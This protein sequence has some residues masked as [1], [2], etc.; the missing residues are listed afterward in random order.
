MYTDKTIKILGVLKVEKKKVAFF[1]G[2]GTEGKGNFDIV[3]G[4]EYL[5][6][7]LFPQK[8]TYQP[9][10]K[11]IFN[12]Q[13]GYFS[14]G[15]KYRKDHLDSSD[16]LLRNFILAKCEDSQKFLR[17]HIKYVKSILTDAD[18]K[19]IKEHYGKSIKDFKEALN[20]DK[21]KTLSKAGINK[22]KKEFKEILLGD[23]DKYTNI[24]NEFLKSLF[25]KGKND[26]IEYD[27]NVG[28]GG[29]LDSYFHT[30]INPQKYGKVKFSKIF[31]YYWACY[32]AILTPV[33]SFL[34]KK[35][36]DI[37][38]EWM[39]TD[40]ALNYNHILN[41]IHEVTKRL[42]SQDM[43]ALDIEGTYYRLI[44]N[45]LDPYKKDIEC[46]GVITTNYYKFCET[47]CDEVIYLNGQLKY[48]E[49]PEMLEVKDISKEDTLKDKIFFPFIFG[50]S[51]VKPIINKYQ[52]DVFKQFEDILNNIDILVILGY[53]IN[54]DDIHINAMLHSYAKSDKRLI[55]VGEYN[56]DDE[57]KAVSQ[58]LKCEE[59]NI[60]YCTVKYGNNS[61]VI[62]KMF[63]KILEGIK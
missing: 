61:E 41:N 37:P 19:L 43:T 60:E 4:Y 52:V 18:I 20:K 38:E 63:N 1:F 50:Q 29:I 51:L 62:N 2:A 11:K 28:V 49:F 14:A 25:K 31:N 6:Q 15:Y 58:K 5:K 12:K 26:T 30:I 55:V 33:V 21:K 39:I 32:F 57:K 24:N 42:Y 44:K 27:L 16:F 53:N 22:I 23:I 34:K 8:D 47:I 40:A 36:N 9:I 56:N 45:E 3:S 48:F 59:E 35:T 46:N 10:L 17:K 13:D 7:S 54:D